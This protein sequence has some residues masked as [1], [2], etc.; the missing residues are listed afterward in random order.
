MMVVHDSA[1]VPLGRPLWGPGN[2][3][4]NCERRLN[5]G[6]REARANSP[7]LVSCDAL[8]GCS[9]KSLCSGVRRQQRA[10]GSEFL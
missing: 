4:F 2:T 6:E 5:E 3:A 10:C 8:F 7:P 1:R 9:G